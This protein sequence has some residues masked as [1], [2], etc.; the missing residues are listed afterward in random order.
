MYGMAQ[1]ASEKPRML[2]NVSDENSNVEAC[3]KGVQVAE[4]LTD[5]AE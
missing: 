3:S 2:Q 4:L 5:A 1:R